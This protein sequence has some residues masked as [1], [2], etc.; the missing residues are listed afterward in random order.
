M[1]FNP[2]TVVIKRR[3]RKRCE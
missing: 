3:L 1:H 2:A